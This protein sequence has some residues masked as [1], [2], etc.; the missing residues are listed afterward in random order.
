MSASARHRER[1]DGRRSRFQAV[2]ARCRDGRARSRALGSPTESHR[3][4][5]TTQQEGVGSLN[6]AEAAEE[7][8]SRN[9]TPMIRRRARS[10][11][12]DCPGSRRPGDDGGGPSRTDGFDQISRLEAEAGQARSCASLPSKRGA[13]QIARRAAANSRGLRF[14]SPT[15]GFTT[16]CRRFTVADCPT[17]AGF[18]QNSGY[19]IAV[20]QAPSSQPTRHELPVRA[21]SVRS[22]G[23]RTDTLRLRLTSFAN[24]SNTWRV[25]S[26]PR[27]PSVML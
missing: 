7:P 22:T 13:S 12:Q 27:Q 14:N 24:A 6:G 11:L 19:G 18:D 20:R 21:S 5:S 8:A 15:T 16:L 2:Q 4:F 1:R 17:P 25:R 23:Q 26:K 3:Y 10:R 9:R